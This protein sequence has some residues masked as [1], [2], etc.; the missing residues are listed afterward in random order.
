MPVPNV[1]VI[2]R[3]NN[4]AFGSYTIKGEE[5]RYNEASWKK[6]EVGLFCLRPDGFGEVKKYL[7]DSCKRNKKCELS[8]EQFAEIQ[9]FME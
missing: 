9:G 6:M 7:I 4:G 3:L 2:T 1:E 5:T 8:A